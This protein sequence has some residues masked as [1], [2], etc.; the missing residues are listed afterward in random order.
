MIFRFHRQL[1]VSARRFSSINPSGSR[2]VDQWKKFNQAGL[3][4]LNQNEL[5]KAEHMFRACL[6]LEHEKDPA[7]S[8]ETSPLLSLSFANLGSLFRRQQNYEDSRA[9]LSQALSNLQRFQSS[10]DSLIIA[11]VHK[12]LAS[13]CRELE[14]DDDAEDHYM[15]ALTIIERILRGD[16]PT[17]QAMHDGAHVLFAL[18][19]LV[20]KRKDIPK[21]LKLY[22]RSLTW[23]KEVFK[24]PSGIATIYCG[25]ATALVE[26][27]P[28]QLDAAKDAYLN[29][30]EIYLKEVGD[31]K[32]YKQV[33]ADYMHVVGLQ[34]SG[35]KTAT[36][37]FKQLRDN[38][39]K[40][41]KNGKKS[42]LLKEFEEAM[43]EAAG[44]SS[45]TAKIAERQLKLEKLANSKEAERTQFSMAD[46][47]ELAIKASAAASAKKGTSGDQMPKDA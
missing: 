30:M 21:S 3:T 47:F 8:P 1:S 35:N 36:S 2:T 34:I 44:A 39:K 15:S 20:Q 33:L 19:S 6:N 31:A 17:D 10:I 25:L 13:T 7:L 26:D 16:G 23:A 43:A 11:N 42:S 9:V 14:R 37:L 45:K 27:T 41:G 38:H 22:Q 40:Q 46:A 5:D 28:Q 29:A 4:Y 24:D 12:E 18:A 32:A